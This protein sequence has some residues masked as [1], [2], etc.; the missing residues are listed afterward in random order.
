MNFRDVEGGL[1]SWF[2]RVP[3]FV[4]ILFGWN[5]EAFAREPRPVAGF[6][7]VVEPGSAHNYLGFPFMYGSYVVRLHTECEASSPGS[8][9]APQSC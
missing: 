5:D 7:V 4:Q 8:A 3:G 2:E 1:W 6:V 9:S